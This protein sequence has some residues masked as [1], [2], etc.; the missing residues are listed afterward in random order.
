MSMLKLRLWDLSGEMGMRKIWP[1]YTHDSD[2]LMFCLDTTNKDT[3]QECKDVFGELLCFLFLIVRI[4][5]T[6]KH[7]QRG[8]LANCEQ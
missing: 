1:N 8:A 5:D 2:A 7:I 6:L 4:V 3:L